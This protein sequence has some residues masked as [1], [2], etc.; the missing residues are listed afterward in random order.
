MGVEAKQPKQPKQ[1][2]T[3]LKFSVKI[4]KYAIYQTALVGLLFVLVQPKHQNSLFRYRSETT[5]TN[6]LLR[7]VA[8]LVS[9]PVLVVLIRTSFEDTLV[10]RT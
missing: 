4:P 7:I 9:V 6:G 5:E 1:T 8:K 10:Q 2:E 3:T